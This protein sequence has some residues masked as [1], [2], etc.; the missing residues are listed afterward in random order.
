MLVNTQHFDQIYR[1]LITVK[2]H[3]KQ[4]AIYQYEC[5]LY[6]KEQTKAQLKAQIQIATLHRTLNKFH[7][8]KLKLTM[9][10]SMYALQYIKRIQKNDLYKIKLSDDHD[11]KDDAGEDDMF[12]YTQCSHMM[13]I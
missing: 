2:H 5:K 7:L 4:Y 8:N 11:G 10:K 1:Y 6:L 9:Y 3:V 13:Q 12:S